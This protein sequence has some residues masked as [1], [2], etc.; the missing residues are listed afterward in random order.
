MCVSLSLIIA[1]TNEIPGNEISNIIT[2][3]SPAEYV[4][5]KP[6][7]HKVDST[8]ASVENPI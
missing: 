4:L 1:I 2:R 8:E 7:H 5:H 6:L 3:A